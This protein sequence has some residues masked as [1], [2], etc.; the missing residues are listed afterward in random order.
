MTIKEYLEKDLVDF[1]K[2]CGPGSILDIKAILKTMFGDIDVV[3]EKSKGLFVYISGTE[4]EYQLA[5]DDRMDPITEIHIPV[6]VS[7]SVSCDKKER[8]LTIS[9]LTERNQIFILKFLI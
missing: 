7:V 2:Y 8:W 9:K 5:P 1:P 4:G 3:T 6:D